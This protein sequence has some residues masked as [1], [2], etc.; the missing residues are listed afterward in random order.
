MVL[1]TDFPFKGLAYL[2]MHYILLTWCSTRHFVK[3]VVFY[4]GVPAQ[5]FYI[6]QVFEPLIYKLILAL[7]FGVFF[8]LFYEVPLFV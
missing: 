1:V 6:Q 7:V 8:P 5:C 2:Q 4:S 3:H